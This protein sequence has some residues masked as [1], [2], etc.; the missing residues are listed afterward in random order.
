M[1]QNYGTERVQ[2][3]TVIPINLEMSES[4]E[5]LIV[6]YNH[7]SELFY[8]LKFLFFIFYSFVHMVRVTSRIRQFCHKIENEELSYRI[9]GAQIVPQIICRPI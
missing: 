6:S 2:A 5:A 4:I 8:T 1:S 3:N 9:S 7:K